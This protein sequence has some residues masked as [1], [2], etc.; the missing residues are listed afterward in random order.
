MSI[1]G[2]IKNGDPSHDALLIK[3]HENHHTVLDMKDDHT[4]SASN[5]DIRKGHHDAIIKRIPAG[6]Q[7]STVLVGEVDFL[8]QPAIAFIRLAEGIVVPSLIEVD[9]PVR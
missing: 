7:G 6:A 2:N 1:D 4:F 5:E 3:H 9:I 8:D